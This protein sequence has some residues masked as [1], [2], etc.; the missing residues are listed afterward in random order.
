M[1]ALLGPR[2]L[3]AMEAVARIIG[4]VGVGSYDPTVRASACHD[5]HISIQRHHVAPSALV[6]YV[7]PHEI[8]ATRRSRDYH[9][10]VTEFPKV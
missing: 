5:K 1:R 7:A 3:A 10:C 8:E 4:P 9:R 6:I 2:K